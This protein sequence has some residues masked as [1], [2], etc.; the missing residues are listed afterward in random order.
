MI[1]STKHG[2][3][4]VKH[5]SELVTEE[6]EIINRQVLVK[7]L[8]NSSKQEIQLYILIS[9]HAILSEIREYCLSSERNKLLSLFV[10]MDIQG[11]KK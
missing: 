1:T 11:S 10:T 3:D 6:L 5:M 9:K 4:S 8:Y 7:M 2:L